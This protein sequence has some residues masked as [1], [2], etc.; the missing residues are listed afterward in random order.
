MNDAIEQLQ[1]ALEVCNNESSEQDH[2]I[3]ALQE[4]NRR[5]K[6]ELT[7]LQTNKPAK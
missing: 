5:L 6:E 3:L 1:T 7:K 4:E 2:V